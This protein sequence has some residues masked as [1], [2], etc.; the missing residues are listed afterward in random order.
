MVKEEE[1]QIQAGDSSFIP[2]S[3]DSFGMTGH[4]LVVVGRSGDSQLNQ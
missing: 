2:H 3:R 4:F 1:F